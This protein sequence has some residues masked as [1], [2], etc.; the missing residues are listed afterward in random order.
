MKL[1]Q[2]QAAEIRTD[3]L[4]AKS[5]M[6]QIPILA[7][8]H[9]CSIK[10]ILDILDDLAEDFTVKDGRLTYSDALK[11]KIRRDLQNGES[12]RTVMGKYGISQSTV[13]RLAKEPPPTAV[14][15]APPDPP[16]AG[17]SN[18][19]P[20]ATDPLL[21]IKQA[22]DEQI[23]RAV[24]AAVPELKR[25]AAG[26]FTRQ[27]LQEAVRALQLF[28]SVFAPKTGCGSILGPKDRAALHDIENKALYFMNGYVYASPFN[29]TCIGG[30][31]DD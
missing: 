17:Q 22:T 24:R 12:Q 9:A 15:P 4:Q 16:A 20:A 8:L 31:S 27:Q 1:T 26:S 3:F 5:R 18:Q 23:A 6:Q 25:H 30:T 13:S 2:E 28:A 10:T 29:Y 11:E 21:T 14:E 19:P 7:Q